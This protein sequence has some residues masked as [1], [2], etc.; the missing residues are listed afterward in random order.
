MYSHIFSSL[1]AITSLLRIRSHEAT[2]DHIELLEELLSALRNGWEVAHI[3][4][5][6][7]F[8]SLLMRAVPQWKI[9]GGIGVFLEV[10]VEKMH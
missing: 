8:N 7:K 4:Y 2:S 1:D 10:D 9:F 3:S 5:A 6:P